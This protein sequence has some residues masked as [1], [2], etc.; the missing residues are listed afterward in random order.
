MCKKVTIVYK[1]IFWFLKLSIVY[2]DNHESSKI[3]SGGRVIG[4]ANYIY[5]NTSGRKSV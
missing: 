4:E 3:K 5:A 1:Y 2:Y